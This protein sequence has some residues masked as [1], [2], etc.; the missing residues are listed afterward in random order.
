M[1]DSLQRS[2]PTPLSRVTR[3][4]HWT[5]RTPCSCGFR[6]RHSPPLPLPVGAAV[7]G[8]CGSAAQPARPRPRAA[9]GQVPRWTPQARGYST[10]ATPGLPAVPAARPPPARIPPPW[11]PAVRRKLRRAPSAVDSPAPA[12]PRRPAQREGDF[13]VGHPRAAPQNCT[14]QWGSSGEP[15]LGSCTPSKSAHNSPQENLAAARGQGYASNQQAC[16]SHHQA[17]ASLKWT[18]QTTAPRQ[19]KNLTTPRQQ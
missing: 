4:L 9:P 6:S 13:L 14:T 16:Q 10:S 15:M 19:P 17:P 12:D 2:T 18:S 5:Y 7:W 3:T 11:G 1:A 8:S